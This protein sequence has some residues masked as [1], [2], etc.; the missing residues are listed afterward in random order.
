MYPQWK[1]FN[2]SKAFNSS[3]INLVTKDAATVFPTQSAVGIDAN[4]KPEGTLSGINPKLFYES[5]I[6][7]SYSEIR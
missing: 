2:V 1:T 3:K 4:R 5:G 7:T 6:Y